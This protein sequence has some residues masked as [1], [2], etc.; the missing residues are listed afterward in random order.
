MTEIGKLLSCDRKTIG[1]IN[2]G[3]RQFQEHWDYPLRSKP[4]KTGPKSK[5]S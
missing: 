1:D 5:N 3:N 2:C 4:L